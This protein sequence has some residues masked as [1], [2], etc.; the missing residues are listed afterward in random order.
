MMQVCT[1][2]REKLDSTINAKLEEIVGKN[3]IATDIYERRL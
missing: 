1:T 2:E 3:D